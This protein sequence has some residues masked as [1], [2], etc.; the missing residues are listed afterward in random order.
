MLFNNGD[1]ALLNAV[2][3][4]LVGINGY[5]L[6]PDEIVGDPMGRHSVPESNFEGELGQANGSNL[7]ES[8]V[9]VFGIES[10]ARKLGFVILSDICL[11][12]HEDERLAIM[13]FHKVLSIQP[14]Q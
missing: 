11:V 12:I 3:L 4:V 7:L 13:T 8:D 5:P 9:G 1:Q 2:G 14:S 10:F 6:D